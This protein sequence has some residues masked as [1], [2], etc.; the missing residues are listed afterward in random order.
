VIKSFRDDHLM[1]F[2]PKWHL[3]ASEALTKALDEIYLDSF[4]ARPQDMFWWPGQA[5]VT[6]HEQTWHRGVVIWVDPDQLNCEVRF[7]DFGD[8]AKVAIKDMRKDLAPQIAR[9][10]VL[11][12]TV[13]I[14]AIETRE[15]AED[16]TKLLRRAAH[17]HVL[18]EERIE[19]LSADL[20]IGTCY[21]AKVFADNLDLTDYLA[22]PLAATVEVIM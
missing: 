8:T 21:Q 17:I 12:F 9:M 1:T 16:T 15:D 7:V 13:K 10:P 18:L 4:F 2:M 14:K 11:C 19:T 6:K 22:L 3:A 20:A 5:C